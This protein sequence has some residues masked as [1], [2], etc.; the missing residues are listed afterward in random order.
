MFMRILGIPIWMI[1]AIIVVI[2]IL[3][4]LYFVFRNKFKGEK[5]FSIDPQALL[6]GMCPPN[7]NCYAGQDNGSPAF[8]QHDNFDYASCARLCDGNSNC[9]SFVF[10][11]GR[12]YL[13]PGTEPWYKP[14]EHDVKPTKFLSVKTGAS[15]GTQMRTQCDQEN[16]N[17]LFYPTTGVGNFAF[18]PDNSGGCTQ[19]HCGG[20]GWDPPFNT[21]NLGLCG[22]AP[23]PVYTPPPPPPVYTPPPPPPPPVIQTATPSPNFEYHY[24]S[25]NW[26]VSPFQQFND[27]DIGACSQA[28]DANGSCK[29]FSHNNNRCYLKSEVGTLYKNDSRVDPGKTLGVK[30]SAIEPPK[31][32][33][34]SETPSDEFEYILQA[35]NWDIP[36]MSDMIPNVDVGACSQECARN[37]SCKS[38]SHNNNRCYLK[39]E[40][41]PY[42][43]GSQYSID[44]GKTL[45]L[46]KINGQVPPASRPALVETDPIIITPPP[47]PP[48]VYTPPPPP[49]Y[50]PPPPPVY[51][52]PPP[53]VYTPPSQTTTTSDQTTTNTEIIKP[54]PK[55]GEV[56]NKVADAICK[57]LR[58]NKGIDF[59]LNKYNTRIK[60]S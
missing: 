44:P 18:V 54:K 20:S 46:R 7:Y 60:K 27:Y 2:V 49:V 52:P 43:Q 3:I 36:P 34:R 48:P 50:I 47:P 56:Y 28:C 12:C 9:K 58:I 35:D 42:Y 32:Q 57:T 13:K 41:S 37:I 24:Q 16:V 14:P 19:R 51:T 22:I 55:I 1:V 8:E 5:F 15:S 59:A 39:A 40:A 45:G 53:P 6:N 11:D 10:N 26:D 33:V 23:P 25:D 21:S 4:I 38:F 31:P 17:G 30:K 29:T